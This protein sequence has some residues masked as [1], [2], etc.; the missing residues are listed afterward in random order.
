M[1]ETKEEAGPFLSRKFILESDASS[2]AAAR[3]Q[4]ANRAHSALLLRQGSPLPGQPR[5]GERSPSAATATAMPSPRGTPPTLGRPKEKNQPI[6]SRCGMLPRPP[7][8]LLAGWH[9]PEGFS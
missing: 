2:F 9:V 6:V 7:P 3:V 8:G 5:G 4:P 1:G